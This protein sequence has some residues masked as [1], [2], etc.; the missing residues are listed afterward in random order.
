MVI[1]SAQEIEL[2]RVAGRVVAETLQLLREK[3]VEGIT[4]RELDRIAEEYILKAG[5]TP[6][7]KGYEGFPATLCTSV[8]EEIVH[9]IPS[10]YVLKSGD[11][12]S[13]DMG[14][15]YK[16]YY[17]DAAVTLAIGE[18]KEKHLALM[19][20][21]E[22]SLY[23]GIAEAKPGNRLGAVSQAIQ[24]HVESRGFAIVRDFVGHGIGSRLH[25]EPHV[26]NYGNQKH[27]PILKEGLVLA[28]EPMVNEFTYHVRTLRDRW[29]ATTVDGG[30][31]AHFEH[32]VAITAGGPEI[33]TTL[34]Q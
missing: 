14:A 2:M 27:G 34:A 30:Y 18:V 7:F 20:V 29:T 13:V 25:E 12:L 24:R 16:G 26:P 10:D 6:A 33:L 32:T 3:A 21:T 11:L 17:G 9:G 28:I 4:T 31:S 22:E 5:C 23:Q 1:K 19:Q 15:I 8:N